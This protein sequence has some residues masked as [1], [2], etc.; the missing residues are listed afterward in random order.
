M[1]TVDRAIHSDYKTRNQLELLQS[2]S[3]YSVGLQSGVLQCGTLWTNFG[4]AWLVYHQ[5]YLSKHIRAMAVG[6]IDPRGTKVFA[7][8]DSHAALF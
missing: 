8:V 1:I 7:N 5:R 2:R 3:A 4:I 6:V